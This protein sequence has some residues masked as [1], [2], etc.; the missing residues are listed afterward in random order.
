[1]S[2]QAEREAEDNYEA[3]ND[4]SPVTS[5]FVDNSYVR[6]T[7]PNL[8]NKVPVQAD[9]VE[10]EDPMVPYDANTDEQLGMSG[11]SFLRMLYADD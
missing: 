8:V 6:E 11:G 1:M 9:E 7:N 2:N 5:S 4:A 3:E 10:V